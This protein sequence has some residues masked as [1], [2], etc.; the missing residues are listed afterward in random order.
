MS[1]Q[2]KHL[3]VPALK[4]VA[5]NQGV[6]GV[7]KMNKPELLE[8]ID[9]SKYLAERVDPKEKYGYVKKFLEHQV[10][11]KSDCEDCNC[12]DYDSEFSHRFCES[13]HGTTIVNEI[14]E[15]VVRFIPR[16][17]NDSSLFWGNTKPY[18]EAFKHAGCKL[19]ITKD[20]G[21]GWIARRSQLLEVM[22]ALDDAKV[23]YH[24]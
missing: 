5:K 18:K 13:C 22:D 12:Y 10:L 20:F 3:T 11:E 23:P 9:E 15:N 7:S 17:T 8:K 1:T 2:L 24:Y 16:Y 19:T 6:K 4:E 14:M 21:A